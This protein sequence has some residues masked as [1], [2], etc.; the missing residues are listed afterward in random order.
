[1]V[2]LLAIAVTLLIAV[3]L[4]EIAHQ[5]VLMVGIAAA[6]RIF[7]LIARILVASFIVHSST[8]VVVS[9]HLDGQQPPEAR[10]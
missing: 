3:H 7:H 10:A 8:E 1:M 5:T 2:E 9:C 4:S 6:L